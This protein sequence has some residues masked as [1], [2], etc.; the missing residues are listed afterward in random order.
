MGFM[1]P[2]PSPFLVV[3]VDFDAI[4][5]VLARRITAVE[6]KTPFAGGLPSISYSLG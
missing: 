1:T 3:D 6:K 4:I 2:L 5:D